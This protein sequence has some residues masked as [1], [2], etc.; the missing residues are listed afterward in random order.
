VIDKACLANVLGTI[1][2]ARRDYTDASTHLLRIV[3]SC[4]DVVIVTF[5]PADDQDCMIGLGGRTR[6]TIPSSVETDQKLHT[7]ASNDLN[8]IRTLHEASML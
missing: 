7:Q 4:A 2:I 1:S 6:L 8:I 3:R 5:G